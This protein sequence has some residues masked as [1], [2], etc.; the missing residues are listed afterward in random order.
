M[1][2][3]RQLLW[4]V[5]CV[6]PSSFDR[7]LLRRVCMPA[8][9]GQRMFARVS[10]VVER[11]SRI[12]ADSESFMQQAAV[13]VVATD[14]G[15]WTSEP[16]GPDGTIGP[17]TVMYAASVT[18]QFVGVLAAQLVAAGRLDVDAPVSD[19]IDGLPLWTAPICV[20]HLIHH[21]SGIPQV[22]DV[23]TASGV[24][25]EAALDNTSALG[26][27]RNCT[28]TGVEAGEC[29]EYNNIGYVLLAEVISSVEGDGVGAIAHRRIFQPLDMTRTTLGSVPAD[30]PTGTSQPPRTI[31]DGGLWTTARD[32]LRWL[33]SMNAETLGRDVTRRVQTVGRLD[34]GTQLRYA[35][36][37]NARPHP[38]GYIFTHGGNW[39]GWVAK[40]WRQPGTGTAVALLARSDEIQLASDTADRIG[41][42]L[43]HPLTE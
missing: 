40:T 12:L 33:V 35:W 37:I 39:P 23:V 36:G 17:D 20:R 3:A 16:T 43:G 21:T 24:S 41:E 1:H 27:L 7:R 25:S 26:A 19:Y 13:A 31:G 14:G 42:V 18:K 38:D 34:D 9:D 22:A 30:L 6:D 10:E 4:K 11:V 5:Q 28:T 29:F 8:P 15:S 2:L 32:L